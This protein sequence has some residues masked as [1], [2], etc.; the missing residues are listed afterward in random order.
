M[1]VSDLFYG[2]ITEKRLL[3]CPLKGLSWTSFLCEMLVSA[4][5][6]WVT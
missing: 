3:S 6:E 4:G 2:I 1:P 5:V